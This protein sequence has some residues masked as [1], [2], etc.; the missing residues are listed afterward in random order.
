MGMPRAMLG[1]G[2]HR[3]WHWM[4]AGV[5]CSSAISMMSSVSSSWVRVM[6]LMLYHCFRHMTKRL[7]RHG[8][9]GAVGWVVAVRLPGRPGYECPVFIPVRT[10]VPR[11]DGH[12]V[13]CR[14]WQPRRASHRHRSSRAPLVANRGGIWLRRSA[15]R[16]RRGGRCSC[17]GDEG[18][19]RS[20][21]H[22][23]S[24]QRRQRR[25]LRY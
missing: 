11:L 4:H 1:S 7:R 15:Q 24:C 8:D 6:P 22:G 9:G 10:C 14:Q 23:G 2:S 17:R 18:T 16:L 25:R 12:L 13:R 19:C 21:R 5:V 3:S 20:Q